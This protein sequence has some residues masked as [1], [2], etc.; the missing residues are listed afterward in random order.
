MGTIFL[1]YAGADRQTATRLKAGLGAAGADVWQDVDEIRLGDRW[2]DTL[3]DALTRCSAYAILIGH[4][5]IQRWVKLELS[6]ALKRHFD[7]NGAFPIFP[8]RLPGVTPED[9]PPFLSIFQAEMLPAEPSDHDY[10]RLAACFAAAGEQGAVI[11]LSPV[12]PYPGLESYTEATAEFFFGRQSETL[13]A[14]ARLGSTRDGTYRRWL[15]IEGPSGVGKS[16][17]VQAGMIPAMRRGWIESRGGAE[18]R[19]WAVALMRPGHEPLLNLA[20][21]LSQALPGGSGFTAL[22]RDLQ[23]APEALRDWCRERVPAGQRFLLVVDQL[24][25]VFTLTEAKAGR[26]QFDALLAAALGDR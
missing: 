13:E 15:Q 2:I 12:C 23:S 22:R 7:T 20:Q 24:E 26:E 17:L 9:L 4:G 16:S 21:S 6:I 8:L 14:L 11:P 19:N 10:R 25:E 3:Q 1:S 18:A 5:G